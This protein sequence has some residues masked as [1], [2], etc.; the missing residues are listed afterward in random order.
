M[1]RVSNESPRQDLVWSLQPILNVLQMSGVNLDVNQPGSVRRRRV[2]LS[3]K[4]LILFAIV[5]LLIH[6]IINSIKLFEEI[7]IESTYMTIYFISKLI[8]YVSSALIPVVLA[9]FKWETLWEQLQRVDQFSHFTIIDYSRLRKKCIIAIIIFVLLVGISSINLIG[10]FHPINDH[11]SQI[12]GESGAPALMSNPNYI[13]DK[14]KPF[15]LVMISKIPIDLERDISL[16]FFVC[17]IWLVSMS[18]QAIIQDFV[19]R[20]STPTDITLHQITT[21]QKKYSAIMDLIEEINP[22]FGPLLLI[23]FAEMFLTTVIFSFVSLNLA[24][25]GTYG[26]PISSILKI[27][28]NIVTMSGLLHATEMMQGK[29]NSIYFPCRSDLP[30][31]IHRNCQITISNFKIQSITGFNFDQNNRPASISRRNYRT[32]S[33]ILT[34]FIAFTAIYQLFLPR[35]NISLS[36]SVK[37]SR[38]YLRWECLKSMPHSFLLY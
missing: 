30:S 4:I 20:N 13:G 31:D 8:S 22:F 36:V 37:A 5:F 15:L 27:A 7:P 11:V 21:W 38:E 33:N 34:R 25:G 14:G 12:V 6:S 18:I 1:A 2:F 24:L 19:A 35:W 32:Q 26:Q 23:N 28:R 29:V 10:L 9:R 3:L 16:V 17:V